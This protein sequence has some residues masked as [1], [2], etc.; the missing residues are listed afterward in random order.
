LGLLNDFEPRVTKAIRLMESSL[1]E[2][3]S[4]TSDAKRLN[5][6]SR[7]LENLFQLHLQTTPGAYYLNLRLLRA[8]KYVTDTLLPMQEI[9]IRTGFN[10]LSSFSRSFK[11]SYHNSPSAYRQK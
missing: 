4:V 11:K 10:S 6:S 2:P 5:I 8:R 9:A 1:D 7:R 3:I